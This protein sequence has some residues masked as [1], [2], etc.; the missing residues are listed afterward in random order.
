MGEYI[1][2]TIKQETNIG[3]NI[4]EM[5]I[6]K[7]CLGEGRLYFEKQDID[8]QR[9]VCSVTVGTVIKR[10]EYMLERSKVI[11]NDELRDNLS[12]KVNTSLNYLSFFNNTNLLEADYGVLEYETKQYYTDQIASMVGIN[13][14]QKR[15]NKMIV[16]GDYS[17][18]PF[19]GIADF[20][21]E[22][23]ATLSKYIST[24]IRNATRF[25]IGEMTYPNQLQMEKVSE[26]K[27]CHIFPTIMSFELS[28]EAVLFNLQEHEHIFKELDNCEFWEVERNGKKE[29]VVLVNLYLVQ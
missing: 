7:W 28:K 13:Y 6:G 23:Y 26:Y 5:E 17:N 1:Q 29:T 11:K 12:K 21:S 16:S 3:E 19:C 24:R 9:Q 15:I 8:F 4:F 22:V 27:K 20:L 2:T 14:Y 10:L 25:H 18:M